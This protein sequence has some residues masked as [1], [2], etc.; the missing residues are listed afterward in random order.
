LLDIFTQA[1]DALFTLMEMVNSYKG[2][3]AWN[4]TKNVNRN[5]FCKVR[6]LIRLQYYYLIVNFSA[7]VWSAVKIFTV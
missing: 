3:C 5:C 4:F 1:E 2:K 7:A 6:F